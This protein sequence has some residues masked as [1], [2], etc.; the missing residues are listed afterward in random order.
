MVNAT[1]S[2]SPKT[3]YFESSKKLLNLCFADSKILYF[4]K[5]LESIYEFII[6]IH[7]LQCSLVRGSNKQ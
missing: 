4:W 5:V 2:Y 6:G 3:F 7:A 1:A